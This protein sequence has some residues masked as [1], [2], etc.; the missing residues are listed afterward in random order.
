MVNIFGWPGIFIYISLINKKMNTI[1]PHTYAHVVIL[2]AALKQP[3]GLTYLNLL[4]RNCYGSGGRGVPVSGGNQ[5][6]SRFD[7]PFA[8]YQ[9]GD[10]SQGIDL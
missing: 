5:A 6:A 3:I 1:L 7:D 2:N 8:L 10:I 4:R 9:Q